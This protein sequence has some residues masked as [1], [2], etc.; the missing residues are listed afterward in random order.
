[1]RNQNQI[2]ADKAISSGLASA[3]KSLALRRTQ[4]I[5]HLAPG[6]S[7]AAR[8]SVIGLRDHARAAV[9]PL[10]PSASAITERSR[11]EASEAARWRGRSIQKSMWSV[12]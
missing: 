3:G 12:G 7:L 11:S 6:I 1:M 5:G 8:C 2:V 4:P 10:V 9:E